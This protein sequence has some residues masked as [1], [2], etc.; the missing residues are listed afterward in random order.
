MHVLCESLIAMD[1][2]ECK[3]L[4]RLGNV[5]KFGTSA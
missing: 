3:E 2:D 4:F 1:K 5:S